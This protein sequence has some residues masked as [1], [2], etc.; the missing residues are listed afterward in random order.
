ME[1]FA[2]VAMKLKHHLIACQMESAICSVEE[3]SMNCVVEIGKYTSLG[4]S[5]QC[6]YVKMEIGEYTTLPMNRQCI[7][8]KCN[9]NLISKLIVIFNVQYY[10][11]TI[12]LY[13]KLYEYN[14]MYH[15]SCSGPLKDILFGKENKTQSLFTD[16]SFHQILTRFFL[17]L[18]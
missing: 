11:K 16:Q 17:T 5:R 3:S 6:I 14:N 4:M 15:I 18:L 10:C 9:S 1:Y 7:Y 13:N 12:T 8:V 2:F